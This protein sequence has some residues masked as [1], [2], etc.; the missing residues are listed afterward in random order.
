MRNETHAE[1]LQPVPAPA[2]PVAAAAFRFRVA[3]SWRWGTERA[4]T[5]RQQGLRGH[6]PAALPAPGR[7]GGAGRACAQKAPSG[8]RANICRRAFGCVVLLC[9]RGKG[10]GSNRLWY[11]SR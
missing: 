7:V 10:V 9:F 5:G 1:F 2:V 4:G 11:S 8:K 3:V 6:R